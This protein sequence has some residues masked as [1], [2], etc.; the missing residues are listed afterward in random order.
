MVT[1][2]YGISIV[3]PTKEAAVYLRHAMLGLRGAM[4]RRES[5]VGIRFVDVGEAE[6]YDEAQGIFFWEVNNPAEA[7][8]LSASSLVLQED[9]A[10]CS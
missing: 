3:P 8:D 5:L 7:S 4:E 1:G 2:E 9:N 6:G 10:A